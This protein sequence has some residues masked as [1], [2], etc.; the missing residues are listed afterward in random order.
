MTRKTPA[1]LISISIMGILIRIFPTIRGFAI[2][3]DFGIYYTI[4]QDFVR[5]GAVVRTFKSPWGGAG[6]G[7]FPVM[8]WIILGIWKSTG[9]SYTELLIK[10]P[11]IFGGLSSII[12]F[13]IA[14]RL[15]GKD[16]VAL[17]AAIFD[18][19]NPILVFQTSLSSI[20]VFGH[21]FGLLTVLSFL[22]Y[23][24]NRRY[25]I[26]VLLSGALL[27]ASHPLSTFMY[28]MAIVGISL[29]SLLESSSLRKR[30]DLAFVVYT[31]SAMTFLY[32]YLFFPGFRGFISGGI[33]HL[34][35]WVVVITYFT[36][37]SALFAFPYEKIRP[38]VSKILHS[39]KRNRKTIIILS[40]T[41]YLV[42]SITAM[43][44]LVRLLPA[45]HAVDALDLI[46]LLMDAF[47][48]L[49]GI[50]FAEGK[51]KIVI[52]GWLS[53]LF[54]A[55]LYS[56][57]TWNMVLYPGRYF[58]YLFEPLSIL[59]AL[60]IVEILR[61]THASV[62]SRLTHFRPETY[63]KNIDDLAEGRKTGLII[64]LKALWK[65]RLQLRRSSMSNARSFAVIGLLV[66]VVAS[67]AVTPYQ[68]GTTVTPSG[69]Q[70]INIP[71]YKAAVWLDQNSSRNYS[72]ATDHI[73]GLLLDGY[74][75]TGT[76]ESISFLWNSTALNSSVIKE[77]MGNYASSSLN[78]TPVGYILIDNYMFK[79]GVW[80]FDG[81]VNPYAKPIPMSNASFLKFFQE[82]FRAVY[83]NYTS[84]NSW[85]LIV[86]VNWSYM[87]E[88]Y[89]LNVP[90]VSV[91]NESVYSDNNI[92]SV[93]F[94]S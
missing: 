24:D 66:I 20:L 47:L 9:I 72:I 59:E 45:F 50:T 26:G 37:I 25:L 62:E 73:L 63:R 14:R 88:N 11:P 65:L 35:A 64:L 69:N 79:N 18:A 10:V 7:D 55:F 81:L 48:G 93:V 38:F 31:L 36:V 70:S 42:A 6:Y 54:I 34:Q 92:I 56:V 5:T 13:F 3:N 74:N 89:H 19:V 2:G 16:S 60:S 32:W 76:F 53:L 78:Y 17:L 57:A 75:L 61:S 51:F 29:A 67:S 58:E 91:L 94:K 87:D 40:L 21:F 86:Q 30:F 43:V 41:A 83:F 84:S 71:D 23:M 49:I 90:A 27:I 44:L 52:L 77:L 12:I 8:Y 46:P 80:G 85:A 1:A 68:V 15:T 4:L 22:L 28:L 33:L 82:P 39:T